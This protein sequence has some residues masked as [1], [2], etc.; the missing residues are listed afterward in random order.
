M[1]KYFLVIIIVILSIFMSIKL[2]PMLRDK[3]SINKKHGISSIAMV[4]SQSFYINQYGTWKKQFIKG[5]NIGAAKPGSFPGEVSITKEDYLRWFKEI[6]KMNANT[7]RVYTI[8]SPAF[9]DAL[10]EYNHKAISPLYVMHGVWINETD[11]ATINNAYDPKIKNGFEKDIQ[12]TIDVIHGRVKIKAEPGH[13]SGSYT[14]DVSMYVSAWILGIEWDPEFV[15]NTNKLNETN[16][17]FRGK[18]LYSKDASPFEN[19]LTEIGDFSIKYESE[20]YGMQRPLSFTNWVTAD[21]LS[22]PNEPVKKEDQVT[23]NVEHIKTNAT[24]IPGCFASYHVY[25]Y[26]PDFMNYQKEYSNFKDSTGKINTYEAYLKDLRKIHTMPVL[27]AE[28][29]IPASRGKAHDNIYMGYNQGNVSETDQGEMDAD[30]LRNIETENY[31]GGLVFSW[32]DE[33]FKRTWNTMDLDIP[34]RRAYWSNTQTNEQEFGLLAFDPGA[35]KTVIE[36]DGKVSD[37][38][39]VKPL[40]SNMDTSIFVTSDEKYMYFRVKSKNFDI[41]KDKFLIP[42]DTISNQGNNTIKKTEGTEALKSTLAIDRAAEFLIQ[43]DGKDNSRIFVDGYYDSFYFSY[44]KLLKMI[45]QVPEI[46]EKD[47][48][49]FNPIYLCLNRELVLPLDNTT[50]PFSKYETGKLKFGNSNPSSKE[51]DSLADFNINKDEIEIRIPW[52]LLNVMDP[53]SKKNMDD[54]YKNGIQPKSMEGVYIGGLLLKDDKVLQNLSSKK[55]DWNK[56]DNPSY[57]ERLKPSYYILQKAF[58]EIGE[59]N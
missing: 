17:S 25:P 58:K 15:L 59:E 6:G 52:Q 53:S 2:Y 33:W 49:I 41:T 48:G 10:Y 51:F 34:D 28:F 27:V 44:S 19:W 4:D 1:K 26:Y 56:W 36:V 24:F 9:Y 31:M 5:V 16:T 30:M 50:V 12:T 55:Y 21:P 40:T 11:I 42:I 22:H 45:P 39:K 7:I 8:L 20:K 46:E 23:V 37:W 13:A 57:H 29:G 54:L 14:K 3:L 47:S 38:K 18:Y 32:Q 35:T 43:I